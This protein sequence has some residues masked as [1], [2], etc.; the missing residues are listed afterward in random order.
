MNIKELFKKYGV[1]AIAIVLF[2]AAAMMY[3]IPAL[4]GKVIKGEDDL[5]WRGAAQEGIEYLAKDPSGSWWTNSQFCGMP[6]YQIGG[7]G[8]Y[9]SE[10][11]LSPLKSFADKCVNDPVWKLIFYLT[12]FYV[13]LLSF[14]ISPWLSIAGAFAIAFSTYFLTIIPAGHNTKAAAIALTALTFAGF[15]FIFKKKYIL[16]A[17][18]TMVSV[19]CAYTYHPQM[20]YYYFLMMGV[21][22]LADLYKHIREKSYKDLITATLVFIFAVGIGIGTRCSNLF[23][24]SEYVSQTIRGGSELATAS[25]GGDSEGDSKGLDLEYATYW[26]Y[27]ID[28]TLTFLIPGFKG[29]ASSMRLDDKSVMYKILKENNI[30]RNTIK[31]IC[32]EAPVYWGAQPST[33]GNVYMGAIIC[34]LFILGLLVVK[35]PYKWALLAATV[36]AVLL[37]WGKHFMWLTELFYNYF[38]LYSKFRAVSSVLIVAEISMPLLAFLALKELFEGS[39]D[40]QK[41]QRSLLIAAGSTAAICLFFALFGA[42]IYDF[43]YEGDSDWIAEVPEWIEDAV[44]AQR[45]HFLRADSLRSLVF[46]TLSA[47]VLWLYMKGKLN[48]KLTAVLLG[49]MILVDLWGIDKRYFNDSDFVTPARHSSVFD[50]EPWEKTLEGD[51]DPDFR[52][53]NLTGNPFSDSRT[54]YRHKSL[55]GYSA[56]KLSRYQDLINEYLLPGNRSVINMLNAKYF[57]IKGE[58]GEAELRRN[59]GALG[60]AWWVDNVLMVSGAREEIDALDDVDLSTTAVVDEAFKNY[61]ATTGHGVSPRASVSVTKCTPK[62]VEYEAYSDRDGIVVFSEIY[63]PYGWKS[64]IDGKPASHFRANY[65]LRAMSVPRGRHIIKFVFDPESVRKGD[66]LAIVFIVIM[67]LCIAVAVGYWGCTIYKRKKNADA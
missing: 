67:Y 59:H 47:I 11:L 4:S 38:P 2:A 8:V 42:L 29:G 46:I 60:A 12:A 43:H 54:S 3:C 22:W 64:T 34:F 17:V 14:G 1:H 58:N 28:E 19:A 25:Q 36:F 41:L 49:A 7:G 65:V 6:S 52:V 26:S 40:R 50:M 53:F 55:G 10:K 33:A 21:I 5:N 56:A 35:G 57:I 45:A 24:N 62:T 48:N 63:Y 9:Q 30:P 44:Y 27:G 39:T 37:S 18:L 20:F 61:I 51:S 32:Q 23:A 31:S 15:R 16:G 66:S 13:L